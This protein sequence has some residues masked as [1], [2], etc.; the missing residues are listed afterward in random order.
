MRGRKE[1]EEVAGTF[2]GRP[3]QG[4]PGMQETGFGLYLVRIREP[5][6]NGRV[7]SARILRKSTLE[8]AAF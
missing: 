6:N 4:G 3:E 7:R 8:S 1:L 2:D 5:V